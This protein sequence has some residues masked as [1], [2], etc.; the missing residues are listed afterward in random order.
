LYAGDF[1]LASVIVVVDWLL[2]LGLDLVVGSIP[3][4]R[5]WG[6]VSRHAGRQVDELCLACVLLPC[7]SPQFA[8]YH[9]IL[10]LGIG[11]ELACSRG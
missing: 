7:L 10:I 1:F 9:S 3:G 8:F 2:I 6:C 4:G 5:F 11:L